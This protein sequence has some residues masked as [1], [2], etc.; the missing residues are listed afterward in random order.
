M[1]IES[2]HSNTD[3]HTESSIKVD[4]INNAQYAAHQ[5]SPVVPDNTIREK[6]TSA[7]V[8]SFYADD[9][10]ST[11]THYSG[12]GKLIKTRPGSAE[13]PTSNCGW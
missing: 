13:K 11:G 6:A 12:T 5:L 2:L 4:D 3:G 8:K 7:I 10:F 1:R 9:G